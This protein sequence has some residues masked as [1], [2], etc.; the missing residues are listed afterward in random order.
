MK[1][2]KALIEIP[3]FRIK[4]GL[5]T[6]ILATLL[7]VGIKA[8]NDVSGTTD[9]EKVVAEKSPTAKRGKVKSNSSKP[10]IIRIKVKPI[11]YLNKIFR[12]MNDVQ[13]EVA[14][15]CGIKPLTGNQTVKDAN[16]KLVKI[17]TCKEY[18]MDKLTHSEPYLTP[19]A[20]KLLKEIGSRFSEIIKERSGGLEYKI[21][22]T[23]VLR[24]P[25]SIK[26]LQKVNSNSTT[27]SAH[28]Y[29][30]TFD[31]SYSD[32]YTEETEKHI[33]KEDLKNILGEVIKEMRSDGRCYVRFEVKQ[34]CFHVTS[35]Q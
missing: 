23:S 33:N 15:K 27:N 24:T 8:C 20:A 35:R 17:S 10:E 26:A 21:L 28:L 30:T 18:K 32:F 1:R 2:F 4:L 25:K 19:N 29:G 16:K 14:S 11:G 3:H 34:G 7:F 5:I 22:V 31:I 6:V 9:I 12:D 13:L